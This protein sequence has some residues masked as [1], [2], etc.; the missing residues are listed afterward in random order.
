EVRIATLDGEMAE[1]IASA[2]FPRAH[3]VQSPQ[4]SEIPTMLLNVREKKADV[5]L[6]ETYHAVRFL[7][8]NPNTLVN[9]VPDRPIRVFPNTFLIRQGQGT[10]KAFLD[11]AIGEL[12]NLGTLDRLLNQYE[13]RA[14][15]FYRLGRPAGAGGASR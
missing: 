8:T 5:A 7:E 14:G 2:D 4:L 11:T 6:V 3:Q 9:L 15:A 1:S 10:L 13:P 12:V